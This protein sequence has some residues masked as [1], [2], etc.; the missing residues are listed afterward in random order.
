MSLR[1]KRRRQRDRDFCRPVSLISLEERVT[2][3]SR[4]PVTR[5]GYHLAMPSGRIDRDAWAKEVETLIARFDPGPRG[6]GNKSAFSRRIGYTTR[7]IDRWL[8]RETDVDPDS[9]RNVAE[10]LELSENEQMDLLTRIGYLTAPGVVPVPPAI[11]NPYDDDVVKE[12]LADESLTETQRKE[13][14]RI[15]LKRIEA[16]LKARQEEYR[17]LRKMFSGQEEAS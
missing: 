15:Q 17:R 9:V 4:K 5:V 8:A 16:D 7:T 10:R 1:Q 12:I 3:M 6:L 11:P 13:L 14:V 2:R